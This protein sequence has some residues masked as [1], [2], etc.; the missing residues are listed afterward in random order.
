MT[1]T[2]QEQVNSVIQQTLGEIILEEVEFPKNVFVTIS[3]IDSAP[4]LNHADVYLTV[5]PD[6]EREAALDI[7]NKN[8]YK[9]QKILDKKVVLRFVPKIVFKIDESEIQANQMNELLDNLDK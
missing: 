5:F 9:I 3:R 6:S 1:T 2:R 8:I 7:L 4:S